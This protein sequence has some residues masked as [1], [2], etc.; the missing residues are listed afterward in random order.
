[1]GWLFAFCSVMLV[2]AAQLVL[3]WAMVQLPPV[4]QTG[5]FID[6]LFTF[7]WPVLALV[8]GLVA[9]GLSMLCWVL[10]LQRLP[11][12][13][14]YPLLSLSYLLVWLVALW[15]PGLNEAFHWGK[16]AGALLILGGLLLI[17]SPGKNGRR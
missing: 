11:L 15:L 3:K 6:T 10:A 9:Y 7:S 2:S 1:M 4:G 8:G 5:L 12:S 16:L 14:A 17:F 13:Q